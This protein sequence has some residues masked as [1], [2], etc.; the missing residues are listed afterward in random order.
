MKVN[1]NSIRILFRAGKISVDGVKEAVERGWI[2]TDDYKKITGK[3]Y[4]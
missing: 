4:V 1:A 2:T 3:E